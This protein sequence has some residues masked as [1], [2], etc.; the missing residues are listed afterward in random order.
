MARLS[1]HDAKVSAALPRLLENDFMRHSDARGAKMALHSFVGV[2][3]TL[4]LM[5]NRFIYISKT[6]EPKIDHVLLIKVKVWW[7]PYLYHYIQK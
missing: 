6:V 5:P 7:L 2:S 1:P 4:V 3:L